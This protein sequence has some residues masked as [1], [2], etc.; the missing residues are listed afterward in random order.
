MGLEPEQLASRV[1]GCLLGGAVGDALGGAVEFMSTAAIRS[2]FGPE[3]IQEYAPA[4]GRTGAITDDTQ[5]TLFTAEGLV[6]AE[7]RLRGRGICNPTSVVHHAYL[8]WLATQGVTVKASVAGG[9]WPDGWLVAQRELWSQRAPGNTCLSALQAVDELCQLPNNNSKGCGTVMRVAPVGV[10]SPVSGPDKTWPAFELGVEVSRLTHGHPSGYYAGGFFAQLIAVLLAGVPLVDAIASASEPLRHRPDALEVLEAIEGAVRLAAGGKPTP[11]R[12]ESL[13]GGWTAEEATAIALYV[14]LTV[15]ELEEG[16]RVAVNHG[17]DSDSTGSL[18]G[19]ILGATRGVEAIPRRWL[20][21]LELRG[22]I[23]EVAR[24]LAS[25][26]SGTFD[27][28]AG[29]RR[30]P[31]W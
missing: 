31:G 5:M 14:A 9:D 15:P 16:V 23:D 17:G 22:V 3:G 25:V 11:D 30:Y 1:R 18:V 29:A 21:G 20:D 6:R 2:K 19:N 4:Y 10:L 13:G 12:I 27:F 7:V 28:D 8:R 26:V 24:D